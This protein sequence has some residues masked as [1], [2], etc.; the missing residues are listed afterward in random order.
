ML[1]DPQEKL[2][3][4]LL[5]VWSHF[6]NLWCALTGLAF[7]SCEVYPSLPAEQPCV[8]PHYLQEKVPTLQ[9]TSEA[10]CKL[11]TRSPLVFPPPAQAVNCEHTW[12]PH[13]KDVFTFWKCSSLESSYPSIKLVLNYYL[14]WRPQLSL[15][16]PANLNCIAPYMHLPDGCMTSDEGVDDVSFSSKSGIPFVHFISSTPSSVPNTGSLHSKIFIE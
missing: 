8:A 9:V 10:L 1:T 14:S 16:P 15:L 12:G 3:W 2:L 11:S 6:E 7:A 5:Q 4:R 13:Q